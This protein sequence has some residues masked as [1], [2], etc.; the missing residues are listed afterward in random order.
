MGD[1]TPN[2]S[3]DEFL[4]SD[5]AARE[6]IANT[7]TAIHLTRLRTVTA[8]GMQI[9]RDVVG[10]AIVMTSAYRNPVINKMVGGV[11]N[12]AHAL[13]YATDSRAAA[14]SP[15]TYASIIRDAMKPGGKLHA[16]VDQ[17]ILES[18]RSIVHISFDPRTGKGGPRGEV[19]T[20]KGGPGSPCVKGLVI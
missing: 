7:P 15:F 9:V 8:P 2:F 12:S 20:Q 5:T 1:L 6:G 17:L 3:L 19:L 13:A 18:G 11:A 4:I 16:K 10:R 14:L